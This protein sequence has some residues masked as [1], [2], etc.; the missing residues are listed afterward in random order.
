MKACLLIVCG[1]L[2]QKPKIALSPSSVRQSPHIMVIAKIRDNACYQFVNRSIDRLPPIAVK[3]GQE[4]T[5][6]HGYLICRRV[7]VAAVIIFICRI[8]SCQTVFN[9]RNHILP[10]NRICTGRHFQAVIQIASRCIGAHMNHLRC[11]KA[12][13]ISHHHAGQRYILP[14][15]VYYRQ[16][17]HYLL[18]FI[19]QQIAAL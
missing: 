1:T 17:V 5:A 6:L 2:F 9:C 7:Y 12:S 15:I 18:Y 4:I 11:A 16:Q 8:L 14:R 10:V 13:E 3:H 19:R